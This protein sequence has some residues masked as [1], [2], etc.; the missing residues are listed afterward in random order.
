MPFVTFTDRHGLNAADHDPTLTFH[1]GSFCAGGAGHVR[2][3]RLLEKL[4]ALVLPIW[5]KPVR[6]WGISGAARR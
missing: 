6:S 5:S 2:L 1:D 3:T 4:F